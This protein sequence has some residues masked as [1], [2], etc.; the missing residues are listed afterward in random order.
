MAEHEMPHPDLTDF[1]LGTLGDAER[2][3]FD[4]H[5]AGCAACQAE[6]AELVELPALLRRAAPP[7]APP[8]DLEQRTMEAIEREAEL[9]AVPLPRAR[10]RRRLVAVAGIAAAL[11]A[12]M[13]IG[14][15][16]GRGPLGGPLGGGA[17]PGELELSAVLRNPADPSRSARAQVREI[18]IGRTIDFDTDQLPILPKSERY[19][20]WFVGPGDSRSSPNRIS[21]G[22]FHPDKQGRSRLR[23]TAAVDPAKYPVLSVTAEPAG[24]DPAWEGPEVLRSDVS[25]G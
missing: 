13:V 25:P 2:D 4:A 12:A 16:L 10:Q 19:E 21:A 22:T 17:P 23:L 9:A 20:L 7:F 5:L 3:R 24:G 14:V 18:G 11:A 15:G 6:V 8:A 1:L